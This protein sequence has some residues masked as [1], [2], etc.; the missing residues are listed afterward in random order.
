MCE[1]YGVEFGIYANYDYVKNVLP[2]WA[3]TYPLWLARYNSITGDVKPFN[4]E[5]WQYTSN[6][7][8]EGITGA[9]D[10][11]RYVRGGNL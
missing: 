11:S 3:A 8:V 1:Y 7:K 10:L 5:M 9:V 4:I 2:T 6:G